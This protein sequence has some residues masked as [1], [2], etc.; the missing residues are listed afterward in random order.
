M[1]G[2]L[3]A[4]E[5]SD[6]LNVDR[7]ANE[8]ST[9]A[10]ED[11]DE[12]RR[13][14]IKLSPA[15]GDKTNSYSSVSYQEQLRARTPPRHSPPTKSA[16][17]YGKADENVRKQTSHTP[18]TPP[19]RIMDRVEIGLTS[20]CAAFPEQQT[21]EDI[22][23]APHLAHLVSGSGRD[24]KPKKMLRL[25][26]NGK[27]SSPPRKESPEIPNITRRGRRKKGE[28]KQ[29]IAIWKYSSAADAV[30][31]GQKIEQIL[32]GTERVPPQK[33]NDMPANR[34]VEKL[35]ASPKPTHP[36]FLGRASRV[37]LQHEQP[38]AT[39]SPTKWPPPQTKSTSRRRAT[40]TPVK[41]KA[42]FELPLADVEPSRTP[43]F[44]GRRP[45]SGFTRQPGA[46]DAPWPNFEN[47]HVRG[48]IEQTQGSRVHA[49]ST[50]LD[51][52]GKKSNESV[53]IPSD[54]NIISRYAGQLLGS[55]DDGVGVL[56]KA[57]RLL[58]S[59]SEI[60][61]RV[62]AELCTNFDGS[63]AELAANGNLSHQ[64]PYL[65]K[66][67]SSIKDDLTPFDKFEC[68]QQLW[69]QKYAPQ[70]AEEVLQQGPEVT[71]LR[72][73]L[74]RCTVTSVDTG[75]KSSTASLDVSKKA[76]MKSAKKLKR[77]RAEDLDNFIVSSDEDGNEL[78]ELD[79]LRPPS[80]WQSASR[81]LIRGGLANLQPSQIS[82]VGNAI[83][84][85]GPHGCGKTAA[86]YA[87]AKE[88]GF[89]VFELNSASRRS[90][91]DVLDKIGDMTENHLVQQVAKALSESKAEDGMQPV[92][93]ELPKDE[94][95]PKQKSMA[96][97][98]KPMWQ[99]KASVGSTKLAAKPSKE[100]SKPNRPQPQ[101]KQKQSLILLEEVDVLYEEDKQFWVTVLT[102]AKHSKRP[103]VLTC[104][105][106]NLVPLNALTLHGILR[107][108]PTP[109]DLAGDYMMLI[110]AREGHL[111]GRD[112]V[113]A[114]YEA[115]DY[116]LRASIMELNFWCQ[117][118]VGAESCLEWV[119]QR[120]PK[121]SDVDEQGRTLRV[122]S[123][124]TYTAG[125]GFYGRDLLLSYGQDSGLNLV[126]QE[127]QKD[128]DISDEDLKQLEW[129]AEKP[130]A[131][132]P[133]ATDFSEAAFYAD[134]LSAADTYCS[135][136]H[137][138]NPT[139]HRIDPTLP[140]LAERALAS[141]P[142]TA[143]HRVL[144]A[145]PSPTYNNHDTQLSAAALAL[146]HPDLI[147]DAAV[148]LDSHNDGLAKAAE[149]SVVEVLLSSARRQL[150]AQPLTRH[151]FACL[152]VLIQP[153]SSQPLIASGMSSFD[154]EF[155]IITTEL[156]PYVRSIAS[157]DLHLED[158]RLRT[159][160][161]LSVGWG[162]KRLRT[163]RAAR[164]AAEGGRRE[165]TR[166]E[167]WFTKE[168]NL[169]S[170]MDTAGAGWAGM[171]GRAEELQKGT[172]EDE[173]A[174][175]PTSTAQSVEGSPE[176]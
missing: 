85:S 164:S 9:N 58:I 47:S 54:E 163:T 138:F 66:V 6:C 80:S 77:K 121:G 81:S 8:S 5:P 110:A 7:V 21:S 133:S 73:W 16:E 175:T 22:A 94:P 120:W 29:L 43:L 161:L 48:N 171:G 125:L 148:A 39:T 35:A 88:L 137:D 31:L 132:Q 139:C 176:A 105:D 37:E 118:G 25:R 49:N 46:H 154:R 41:P 146:T 159:S 112:A 168:L 90:G 162:A 11:L 157:Y 26:S 165:E 20:A 153:S 38:K 145:D 52:N 117:M 44:G 71:I 103:I 131:Q 72:D 115:T 100:T 91:K 123:N 151:S 143:D 34:S 63:D 59:G 83:L 96:S 78:E 74:K 27:F 2:K 134:C 33:A 167:R 45:A 111:L 55:G 18:S 28:K 10:D 104:N 140:E 30:Q 89:E 150:Q 69:I 130:S 172:E 93:V 141:Y 124:D 14:R 36:F 76:A 144:Q 12:D 155:G 119:Y 166:R 84:L 142:N 56:R 114:L 98:F 95:D 174:A 3:Q 128:W 122:V 61:E 40:A 101:R 19:R 106:E 86:V 24:D 32:N 102:L 135:I 82:K 75:S 17:Q 169:R 152:D 23:T 129:I 97:F 126:M 64:H 68:E 136:G 42:R 92:D 170:V 109:V 13:K 67:Y 65:R 79:D 15:E 173:I 127:A 149:R 1:I 156:A 99:K 70:T 50:S 160:N 87:V 113:G 4:A 158:L 62:S 57:N 116:D 108:T 53:F 60:Q 147:S 51:E 107:F